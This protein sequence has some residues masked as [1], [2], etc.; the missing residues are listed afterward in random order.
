MRDD[1]TSYAALRDSSLML[2]FFLITFLKKC[3]DN[4]KCL[5]KF[6]LVGSFDTRPM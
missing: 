1:M 3:F 6:L 2:S 5:N 4:K